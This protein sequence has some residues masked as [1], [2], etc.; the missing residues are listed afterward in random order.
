M[1][2]HPD[3]VVSHI[4][5]REKKDG[6]NRPIVNL[7]QVNHWV[8]YQHFKMEGMGTVKDLLLRADFM[9]KL[10]LKDTYFCLPMVSQFQKFFCFQWGGAVCFPSS[11]LRAGVR[12]EVVHETTET[13]V[14]CVETF[15]DPHHNLLG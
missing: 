7:R 15:G 8:L 10:D 4:F 12:A 13:S 9:V 3:Q 11:P 5:L 2:P 6:S 14:E 1:T